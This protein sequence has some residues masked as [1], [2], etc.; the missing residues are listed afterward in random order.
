MDNI[1][2]QFEKLENL[3]KLLMNKAFSY[4]PQNFELINS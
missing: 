1:E 4:Q 2:Q 3:D